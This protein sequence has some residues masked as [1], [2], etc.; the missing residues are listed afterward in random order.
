MVSWWLQLRPL[1]AGKFW[2]DVVANITSTL[3]ESRDEWVITEL[4]IDVITV[5]GNLDHCKIKDLWLC[6]FNM[7]FTDVGVSTFDITDLYRWGWRW[8][9]TGK[10]GVIRN[11]SNTVQYLTGLFSLCEQND[12]CL[13]LL[14]EE[15]W[16][17]REASGKLARADGKELVQAWRALSPAVRTAS[18]SATKEFGC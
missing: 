3:I 10:P 4:K 12:S 1:E 16:K 9:L 18:L 2:K 13:G 6:N 8:V 7:N 5:W 14:D 15:R 17:M 11:S